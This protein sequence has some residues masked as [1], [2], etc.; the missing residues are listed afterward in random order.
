MIDA[1]Q[2]GIK[3]GV[4]QGIKEGVKQGKDEERSKII[5]KLYSKGMATSDIADIVGMTEV[6]VSQVLDEES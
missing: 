5:K 6:E 3:Q 1:T 2:K 4:E